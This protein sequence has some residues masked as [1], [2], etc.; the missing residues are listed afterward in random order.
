MH[1]NWLSQEEP[2]PS[3]AEKNVKRPIIHKFALYFNL[4]LFIYSS[5][6]RPLILN[7]QL[8]KITWRLRRQLRLILAKSEL[9]IFCLHQTCPA[10]SPLHFIEKGRK[11]SL[12]ISSCSLP[13][14]TYTQSNRGHSHS[15]YKMYPESCTSLRL[16]HFQN[17]SS[18]HTF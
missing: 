13:L 18:Y 9:L 16:Y 6:V 15:I 10:I 14:T 4:L 1:W 17:N 7:S 2:A 12:I 5:T 8:G 3:Q 11:E